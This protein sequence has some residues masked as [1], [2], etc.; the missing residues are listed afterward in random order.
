MESLCPYCRQRP[1]DSDDHIFS[2]F[3]G[4]RATIRCC[5]HCNNARF[6]GGFEGPV[7]KDLAPII[8]FLT[9]SG[10]R[11]NR[12]FVHKKAWVDAATGLEYDLDSE[13]QSTPTKTHVIRDNEGNVTKF[14]ARSKKEA[15]KLGRSLTR[16]GRSKGFK[17]TEETR[18]LHPEFSN[19]GIKIGTEIRQLAVKMCVG[20]TQRLVPHEEIIDSAIRTF[21]LDKAPER[22]P[23]RHFFRRF[24]V[25]DDLRPPLAHTIYVEGDPTTGR[26]YGVVQFFGILQFYVPLRNEYKGTT[27]AVLGVLNVT[28]GQEEFTHL[29]PLRLEEIPRITSFGDHQEGLAQ[30]GSQLNDQVRQAFG[31]ASI[32]FKATEKHSLCGIQFQIPV[33]WVEYSAA[34]DVELELVP[35]RVSE[36]PFSLPNDAKAWEISRDFG[37]T[38]IRV[39]ET[40]AVKWNSGKIDRRLGIKHV[41]DP[42]E[43]GPEV[44]LRLG[45]DY[46]CPIKTFRLHYRVLRQGWLGSVNISDC[47]GV[48]NLQQQTLESKLVLSSQDMPMGRNPSWPE[49]KDIDAILA[50]GQLMI[51]AERWDIDQASLVFSFATVES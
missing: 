42:E 17:V 15:N 29:E 47:T 14:I 11:P 3:L 38:F 44:R 41:Y 9:F 2:Q 31:E 46:W 35:D 19:T 43:F 51:I 13:R 30:W 24:A 45:E 36:K 1:R 39:F 8:V 16:K 49:V 37:R 48:L 10:L 33:L 6:G 21:L 22:S 40:F 4:G 25:L 34:I 27:F 12:T 32:V 23:V 20:L 5:S 18:E 26:C 7:S 50:S 28:N